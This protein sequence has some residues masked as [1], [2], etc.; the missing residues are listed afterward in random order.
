MFRSLS[1]ERKTVLSHRGELRF[2]DF[3]ELL[4]LAV[5]FLAVNA[6][7]GRRDDAEADFFTVACNDR[8]RDAAIDDDR[9]ADFPR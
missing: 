9:L 3:D 4:A 8:N 6:D 2:V 1:R 5:D 7:I